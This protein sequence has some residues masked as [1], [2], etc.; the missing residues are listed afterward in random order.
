MAHGR[1]ADMY[2]EPVAGSAFFFFSS[3]CRRGS[4]IW[5]FENRIL[6]LPT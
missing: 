6:D 1:A 2:V 4:N 5:A 3:L